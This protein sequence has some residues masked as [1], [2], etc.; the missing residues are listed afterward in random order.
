MNQLSQIKTRKPGSNSFDLSH[1]KLLTCQMGQIIPNL[2]M[3]VVP[4]D[5]FNINTETLVRLAPMLAP[6]MHRIDVHQHYFYVPNRLLWTEWEDFITGGEQGTDLPSFPRT[7]LNVSWD[8]K[9]GKST[10]ADYLGIP[11]IA[12]DTTIE[13]STLPFRAY[14]TI[15]NEYYRDQNLIPEL[16]IPKG[17]GIEGNATNLLTLSTLRN[18]AW[19]KDYFTNALP[20]TQ[21]GPEVELPL[22]TLNIEYLAQSQTPV[23]AGTNTLQTTGGL[24][25]TGIG[26]STRIENIDE[27]LSSVDSVTINALRQAVR[28]QE[29]MEISA[30]AGSR[31]IEQIQAHYGVRIQD[32]RLQRPEYLGGGKTPVM[33]SEVIT[34]AHSVDAAAKKVPVG[35][36]YGHALSVGSQNGCSKYVE[37]HGYIIGLMSIMPRTNYYQGLH[38]H[39]NKFDKFDY[40]FPSFANLGEQEVKKEE[41]FLS[42]NPVTNKETFGYQQ[43][44]AEYKYAFGG[45]HG[46]FKDNM[47]YWHL[48]RKFSTTP[49]LNQSFI[50]CDPAQTNRV[51]SVTDPSIHKCWVQLYHKVNA[52]RPMPYFSIPTL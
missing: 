51:F 19:E 12:A 7:V 17:S 24:L 26:G 3:E 18:R 43:R 30:R 47:E 34:Q 25:Q 36:M 52:Q 50:E 5:K 22:G 6:V 20:F 13:V 8:T 21:R 38:K 35:D 41:I 39:W 10:L 32:F 28:L 15:Y 42:S 27:N 11:A 45:I 4:G 44:Y 33:I 14:Q 23:H 16:N 40:Y 9:L 2:L 29:W 49:T 1:E 48:A 37:E 31:Y 46:D